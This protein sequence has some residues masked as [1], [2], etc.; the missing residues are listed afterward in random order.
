MLPKSKLPDWNWQ[1]ARGTAILLSSNSL[2]LEEL[3]DR[4]DR[5][6]MSGETFREAAAIKQFPNLPDGLPLDTVG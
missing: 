6:T 2:R 1:T 5:I 4:C 3:L